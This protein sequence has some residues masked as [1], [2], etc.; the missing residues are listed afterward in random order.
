MLTNFFF[1]FPLLGNNCAQVWVEHEFESHQS[2]C[3]D[4]EKFFNGKD[5]VSKGIT[6]QG[7]CNISNPDGLKAN[8]GETSVRIVPMVAPVLRQEGG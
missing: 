1:L 6:Q 2:I 8:L 4:A 5:L 3:T 7:N